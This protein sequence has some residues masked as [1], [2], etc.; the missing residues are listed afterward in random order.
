L[1]VEHRIF[2][3]YFDI[4]VVNEF[5]VFVL[6]LKL[7]RVSEIRLFLP[8]GLFLTLFLTFL[9][10]LQELLQIKSTTRKPVLFYFL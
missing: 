4:C 3:L 7:A 6:L 2:Y 8:L 5:V 10:F 9:S 1:R